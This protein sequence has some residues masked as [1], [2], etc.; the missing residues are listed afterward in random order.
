MLFFLKRFFFPLLQI[1]VFVL[2]EREM[3]KFFDAW[4]VLSPHQLK[5]DLNDNFV[6]LSFAHAHANVMVH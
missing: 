5:L 4:L 1:G 6:V 3:E 2:D